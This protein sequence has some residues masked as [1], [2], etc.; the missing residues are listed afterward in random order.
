[1]N[2]IKRINEKKNN[3]YYVKHNILY[4][5][6]INFSKYIMKDKIVKEVLDKYKYRSNAGVEKYGVTLERGDLNLIE[7]LNHLQEEL[8]DATLYIQ[9]LKSELEQSPNF[10]DGHIITKESWDNADKIT[11]DGFV[12]VKFNDLTFYK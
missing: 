10:P 6:N 7:W 1:L 2:K 9:K 8:M 12:Y 11:Q 3:K 5:N 4:N